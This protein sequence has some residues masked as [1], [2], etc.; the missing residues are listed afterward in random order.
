MIKTILATS[1]V[2]IAL[3]ASA[4]TSNVPKPSPVKAKAHFAAAK[5]TKATQVAA[6]KTD[7]G[8]PNCPQGGGDC[9]TCP[10]TSCGH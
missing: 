2:A 3:V 6:C 9:S 5:E 4:M 8:V 10:F 1:V 7:C